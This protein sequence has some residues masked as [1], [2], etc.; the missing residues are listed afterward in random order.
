VNTAE[1]TPQRLVASI[2]DLVTL[3]DVAMRIA[4]MVNDPDS[5]AADIGREVSK[6]P[7][8]TARLLRIANSP[9]LGQNGKIATMSRAITLLGVRQ[10]RDLT[11]GLTAVRTFDGIGNELVTMASFWRHSVLCAVA[12]TQIA[13]R[14]K[15]SRDDSPFIAG[16]LHD[17]GQLVLYSRAPE[18]A[19]RALLM[20]VDD[21]DDAGLYVCEREVMGFDH[22]AVGV[23]LA[24]NWGLPLA[25]QECIEFH[26]EPERAPS[27]PLEAATIHV[28]NSVAVLAEI[29]STDLT[30]AP[31]ISDAALRATKLD[32]ASLTE[33]IANTSKAAE[34][35]LRA[36]LTEA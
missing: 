36:V 11:V 22:A 13:E 26:H 3:P 7:A 9:A 18:L 19:R 31:R 5:S 34:D 25:L 33:I 24:R 28:A 10:V 27:H 17:I 23:A 16:L 4:R 2:K 8:L 1:L 6:D 14:R 30:D 29:G 21:P 12:A 20:S 32:A 35:V 15:G